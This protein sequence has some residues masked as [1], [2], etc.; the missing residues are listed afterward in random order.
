MRPLGLS[1]RVYHRVLKLARTVA[2]LA[3]SEAI[4]AQHLAEGE[5]VERRGDRERCLP[6][7]CLAFSSIEQAPHLTSASSVRCVPWLGRGRTTRLATLP[8]TRRG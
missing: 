5:G 1:A 3:G 4:A 6:I 8:P 7:P 2:D